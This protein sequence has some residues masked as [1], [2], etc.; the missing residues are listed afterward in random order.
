[1]ANALGGF[2]DFWD[3]ST[4]VIR[5]GAV[6]VNAIHMYAGATGGVTTLTSN[7]V[8]CFSPTVPADDHV[9]LTFG[10]PQRLQD[11]TVTALGTNVSIVVFYA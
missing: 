7:G 4:G 6:Q 8:V 10:K 11:L 2:H 9:I 1:M 5:A 3:T